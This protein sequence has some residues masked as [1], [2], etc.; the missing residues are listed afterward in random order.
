MEKRDNAASKKTDIKR[1]TTT[2][3][4]EKRVELLSKVVTKHQLPEAE[5]TG[6]KMR[7]VTAQQPPTEI[8]KECGQTT[9]S[10]RD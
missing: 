6:W 2:A 8:K 1:A 4:R 3:Y 10:M 5:S 7:P 9:D